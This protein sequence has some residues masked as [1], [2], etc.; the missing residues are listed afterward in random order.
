MPSI[1]PLARNLP[2]LPRIL[3]ILLLLPILLLPAGTRAAERITLEGVEHVRNGAVPRDGRQTVTLKEVWRAGGEDGDLMFGLVPRVAT[4]RQGR[5]YVLD[6][7]LCQVHVFSPDGELLRSLFREGEGPGEVRRPRDLLLTGDGRVGLIQE[8]PGLVSF[9][10]EAGNPA[11]R[12]QVGGAEGGL[13]SLTAC[14]A[15]GDAILLTGTQVSQGEVPEIQLRRNFLERYGPDGLATAQYA[16]NETTYNFSNFRFAER[17]HMPPF[18]WT[19]DVAPDGTVYTV[20]D[21]DKY[22]I[23]VFRPEGSVARVIER[24]Y[25]PLRRTD[26]EFQMYEGMVVSAMAGLP[27]QPTIEIEHDESVFAYL[28]RG[29]QLHEDGSLWVLTGRGVR[30]EQEGVMAVFDVFAAD[31]E[32]VRQ[33]ALAAPQDGM[34][35]GMFLSGADR[36]LV[37]KGYLESLAA[38][39]GNGSTFAGEDGEAETPEV[40]CYQMVR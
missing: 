6:S 21:R 25:E 12:L 26:E 14:A 7:Q 8:F 34:K 29:L 3:M 35:V 28:W 31:G 18:W 4:D 32:F 17:E 5:V 10:D 36:V 23:T 30:D 2:I 15:A 19:F 27:F 33:V 40:I 38:Q 39:F 11:G 13:S 1:R 37:V 20:T 24:R 9:V 22:A 16:S